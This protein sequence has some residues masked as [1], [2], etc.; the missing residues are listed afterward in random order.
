MISLSGQ[1]GNHAVDGEWRQEILVLAKKFRQTLHRSP[2][3]TPSEPNNVQGSAFACELF[4]ALVLPGLP[5]HNTISK[6]K[7]TL[8]N[9]CYSQKDSR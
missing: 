5:E 1:A 6:A 3:G 9:H 7:F 2:K 8:V 4:K